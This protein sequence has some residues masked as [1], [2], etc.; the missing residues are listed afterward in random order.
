MEF[1]L[2]LFKYRNINVLYF[3][4]MNQT[5]YFYFALNFI[6]STFSPIL[7]FPQKHVNQTAVDWISRECSL[8]WPRW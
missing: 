4:G 5:A 2:L 8:R 3:F 7:Y 6:E 1:F